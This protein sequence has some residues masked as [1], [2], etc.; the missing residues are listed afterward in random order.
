MPAVNVRRR[1]MGNLERNAKRKDTQ[2]DNLCYGGA[3][4]QARCGSTRPASAVPN[5]IGRMPAVN[6]RRRGMGNPECNA[7]RKDTQVANLCVFSVRIGLAASS[8]AGAIPE[9]G[10]AGSEARAEAGETCAPRRSL[11]S[12]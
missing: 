12:V 7:K 5:R 8:L 6:V 2:V 11:R 9:G 10:A 4:S 1:G 3:P